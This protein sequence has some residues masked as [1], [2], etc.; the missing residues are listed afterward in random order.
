MVSLLSPGRSLL[1]VQSGRGDQTNKE[2]DRVFSARFRDLFSNVLQTVRQDRG[3]FD[4]G[5]SKMKKDEVRL[6]LAQVDIV[7]EILK[8]PELKAKYLEVFILVMRN[9]ISRDEA[10]ARV[11]E[12]AKKVFN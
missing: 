7:N 9:K 2:R 1:D 3:L 6:L 8:R 12:L 5:L 11:Q 10:E 4:F